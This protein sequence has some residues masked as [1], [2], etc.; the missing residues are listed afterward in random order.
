MD[1]WD[2]KHIAA[3]PDHLRAQVEERYGGTAPNRQTATTTPDPP[4]RRPALP[5]ETF[6]VTVEVRP[7]STNA[8]RR[9]SHWSKRHQRDAVLK[10]LTH[11]AIGDDPPRF[12]AAIAWVATNYH[13]RRRRDCWNIVS[14]VKPIVDQLQADGII[15]DDD[16]RHLL[17]PI[18][19]PHTVDK[20]RPESTTIVLMHSA[21][22]ALAVPPVPEMRSAVSAVCSDQ[23]ARPSS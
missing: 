10:A 23:P 13:T 17:G 22:F 1:R 16:D 6:T 12:D 7:M 20:T 2:K 9:D 11:H 14:S 18:P 3:W 4:A 21:E 8:E 19:T 5:G 15:P